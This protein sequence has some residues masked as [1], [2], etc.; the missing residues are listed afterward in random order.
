MAFLTQEQENKRFGL[1]REGSLIRR[2]MVPQIKN[3]GERDVY[4]GSLKNYKRQLKKK[5]VKRVAKEY[6]KE[7][8]MTCSE[9]V[10]L[11]LSGIQTGL[12]TTREGVKTTI[13]HQQVPDGNEPRRP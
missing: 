4:I 1:D 11:I 5:A 7:S 8:S 9:A 2:L 3:K 12:D 6:A 10:D 13:E